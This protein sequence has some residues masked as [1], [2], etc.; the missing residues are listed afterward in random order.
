MGQIDVRSSSAAPPGAPRRSM[1]HG[2]VAWFRL[3]HPF[4]SLVVAATGVGVAALASR[5]PLALDH[6]A[7]LFC[8][9]AA[10]Q[11][12][13][14]A[15]N[16]YCDA[17]LDAVAKPGRPIPSGLVS[18]RGA[19]LGTVVLFASTLALAAPFGLVTV[20]YTVLGTAAGLAYDRWL[21]RTRWSWT[22]Y[23]FG[24]PLLPLWAW[25]TLE[26]SPAA[27]GLAYPFGALLA[28]A[29]HLANALPDA[30]SDRR[31][32]AGG[33]VQAVGRRGA[34]LMLGLSVGV[35]V[36]FGVLIGLLAP[37]SRPF[38]PGT[39]LGALI[40]LAALPLATRPST[41]RA[42][43]PVLVLGSALLAVGVAAALPA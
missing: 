35:A 19:L 28:L 13:V 3:L 27:I 9:L 26:E 5:Q 7:R 39:L 29:L 16:D 43:F 23:V 24:L 10:S 4:P 20:A 11:F 12:A 36:A 30:E 1:F 21:K 31:A 38:S 14:G 25:S 17:D 18:A 32:G 15:F 40:A 34:V 8:V 37:G 2:A 6:A 33:L 41:D 22:P 42:A